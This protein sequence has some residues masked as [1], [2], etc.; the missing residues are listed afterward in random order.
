MTPDDDYEAWLSQRREVMPAADLTDRIMAT[1]EACAGSPEVRPPVDRFARIGPLLLCTAASL[2]FV[3]RIAA[4]VGNLV[5]PTGYP[6]FA[7]DQ[8]IEEVPNE[9]SPRNLSRS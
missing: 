2:I 7:I 6:E 4:L 8:R 9:H 5:F 3:A 1:V